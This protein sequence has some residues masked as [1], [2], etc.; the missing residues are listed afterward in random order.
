M[1]LHGTNPVYYGRRSDTK[2]DYEWIVRID[3]EGCFVTDPIEDWEKDDD[4]REEAES[5]GTLYERLDVYDAR[6]VLALW[7][8]K[9]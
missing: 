4:Y 2:S 1:E 5:N 6:S 7:N 8:R 9:P 3:E